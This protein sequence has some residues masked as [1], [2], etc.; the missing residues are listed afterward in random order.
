MVTWT[1]NINANNANKENAILNFEKFKKI[2]DL[3]L[4]GFFVYRYIA[5]YVNIKKVAIVAGKI[6][7]V[8][9]NPNIFE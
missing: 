5:I 7:Y 6:M 9:S 4:S 1:I 2:F 3:I 8:S